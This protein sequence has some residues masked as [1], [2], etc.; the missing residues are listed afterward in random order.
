MSTHENRLPKDDLL[1]RACAAVRQEAEGLDNA[2]TDAALDRVRERLGVAPE[3]TGRVL[4]CADIQRL[5][6]A[7]LAGTLASERELLVADHTRTCIACRRA[8][9]TLES[10]E[11]SPTAAPAAG[12]SS[13]LRRVPRWAWAAAAA[14][15]VLLGVQIAVVTRFLPGGDSMVLRVLRGEVIGVGGDRAQAFGAGAEVPY[16]EELLTPRGESALVQLADGSVVELKER[17][18][19]TVMGRRAGTTLSLAG[20]NVIVEAAEQQEGRHLWVDTGDCRVQVVG[21]VF[22]VNHGTRGSRVSVFEGEVRVAQAG[23]QERVLLPGDQATTSPRVRQVALAEEVEW[24]AQRDKHLALL[25]GVA[26]LQREMAALPPAEPRFASELLDRLPATTI[27]YAALP[28]LSRSLDEGLQRLQARLAQDPELAQALGAGGDLARI[29]QLLDRLAAVGGEL[30]DE[31]VAAAWTGEGYEVVGPVVL[32]PVADPAGLRA[33][34]EAEVAALEQELQGLRVV[35]VDDPAAYAAAAGDGGEHALLVWVGSGEMA[36]AH[37]AGSLA[38]AAEAMTGAGGGFADTPF[39]AT[40]A[41]RYARGVDSLLAVDLAGVLARH[42]N[43]GEEREKLERLGFTGV[44]HL[45]AE[46]WADGGT[47]RRQ[48][49]LSFDGERRGIPSWLAA[50]APMGALDLF[51][52]EATTVMSFVV[53]EPGVLIEDVL[54]ALTAEERERFAAER[55]E[56]TA[57]HGWDPIEDLAMPLGGEI[58]FGIDGPL[59][60]EPAWKLV[61]EV[62]DPARLQVGIERLVADLDRQLQA[63]GEGTVALAA[64]G[65][66]WVITRTKENGSELVAHYRYVDG[67]LVATPSPALLERALRYRESGQGLLHAAKLR[68]LLP[69]DAEVNLSALWYSDLS[70]IAGALSGVAQGA[71]QELPPELQRLAAELGS[72]GGPTVVFAYGEADSIRLSSSS[73]RSPLGLA[74]LFLLRGTA[75]NPLGGIA[76]AHGG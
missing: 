69:P 63:E 26:M 33:R 48:A 11:A 65:D 54:A 6:P 39:H 76:E 4:G 10:P 34:L 22:A 47:T 42:G 49:V 59:V 13:R 7:F 27:F 9:K 17:T 8:L 71:A 53:K 30:G 21:T 23:T 15:V 64:E 29:G 32:A 52:A 25:A 68:S 20:G 57:E 2:R 46:Q 31:L 43:D 16:G 14:V 74:D 75:I 66:G 38:A 72:A 19:L 60:P 55:A 51:S 5:L 45:I 36:I 40:I 18:R 35:I 24:S 61:V 44:R 58:A 62:Y 1:D 50:P 12:S 73:P 70:G 41:E 56:F 3:V 67:Y 28:N 37:A